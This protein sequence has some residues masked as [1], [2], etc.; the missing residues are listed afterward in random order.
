MTTAAALHSRVR[1]KNFL[2][3]ESIFPRRYRLVLY[4]SRAF[5]RASRA[6]FNSELPSFTS[7]TSTFRSWR[8]KLDKFP[9][10]ILLLSW[11]V[12]VDLVYL[13]VNPGGDTDRSRVVI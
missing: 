11:Q 5:T 12:I 7:P 10:S 9:I 1:R 13:A 2:Y 6:S 3:P 8:L 4:C